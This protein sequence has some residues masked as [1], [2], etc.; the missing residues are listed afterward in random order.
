[1]DRYIHKIDRHT[2][3]YTAD[4][5]IDNRGVSSKY[6][7]RYNKGKLIHEDIM[8]SKSLSIYLTD[9]EPLVGIKNSYIPTV[10][11]DDFVDLP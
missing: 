2:V 1:M 5:V 7:R 8:S 3:V 6:V 9:F 10:K 4:M 11:D